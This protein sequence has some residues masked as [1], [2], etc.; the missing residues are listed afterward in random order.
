MK[1]IIQVWTHHCYNMPQTET[2]NYWGL[3]DILRGTLQLYM[4]SKK[5]G[6]QFYVDTS[7]HPIGKYLV[8]IENPY[9]NIIQANRDKITM[10]PADTYLEEM[11][12][13]LPDDIYC[14]FTNAYCTETF[15][16]D[17]KMF[18]KKLLTPIQTLED[19]IRSY[20]P[21]EPYSILHFRLG[22][23]EL[24]GRGQTNL[25]ADILHMIQANKD[26]NSVLISDSL[27]LKIHSDVVKEVYILNTVPKH[28]GKCADIESIKGTLID[29][30]LL[31]RAEI[32]KT[33]S[34]YEWISGFVYWAHKIYDIPFMPIHDE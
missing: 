16:D 18:M 2:E 1:T 6:F 24:V 11:I 32:I 17:S 9:S 25:P 22:D 28:L 34:C 19:E 5:L 21:F 33:Y 13:G 27:N 23:D 30:F 3:G 7:L 14:F 4:L 26:P 12:Q 31:T 15:D 10:I 29:F 20:I 8:P